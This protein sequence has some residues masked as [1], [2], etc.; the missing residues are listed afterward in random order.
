VKDQLVKK[1]KKGQKHN[2]K[3]K[4]IGIHKELKKTKKKRKYKNKNK[5]GMTAFVLVLLSFVS[6]EP[7]RFVFEC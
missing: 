2:T 7:S 6:C 4:E 5:K 3:K 1:T